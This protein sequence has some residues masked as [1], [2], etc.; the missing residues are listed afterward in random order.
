M[1]ISKAVITAAGRGARQYLGSDSVQKA[2]LP[3]VDR[4]GM[5]KP[6][7]QIIAEEG[8]ESG[9]ERI[10]VICAPGDE[11]I[12]RRH[13]RDYSATLRTV[14]KDSEWAS[15]QAK[16]LVDGMDFYGSGRD[17]S[18]RSASGR[19]IITGSQ[20]L[21]SNSRLPKILWLA[22]TTDCLTTAHPI[23]F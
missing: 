18:D 14:F 1:K 21:V 22:K 7:L 9:I 13:F 20:S 6:V 2:M 23:L 3:I 17:C 16:R 12:Y 15:E 4:D 11:E 8:L 19:L 5:T 10:C